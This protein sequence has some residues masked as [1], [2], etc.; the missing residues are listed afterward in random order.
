M[1]ELTYDER[2]TAYAAAPKVTAGVIRQIEGGKIVAYWCGKLRGQFVQT[3]DTWKSPTKELALE[4]ARQFREGCRAE[5]IAKG[6]L[7]PVT[8][9]PLNP[10]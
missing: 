3:C 10:A 9:Q 1:P 4:S 2:L 6:F 8:L 5:A 7:D